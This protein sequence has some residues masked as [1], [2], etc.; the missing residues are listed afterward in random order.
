MPLNG[1]DFVRDISLGLERHAGLVLCCV[2]YSGCMIGGSDNL[3]RDANAGCR[4]WIGH[5]RKYSIA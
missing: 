1:T 4:R 5:Y 3:M 2:V